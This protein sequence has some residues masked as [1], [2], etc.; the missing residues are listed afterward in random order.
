MSPCSFH[1]CV[2]QTK[3]SAS[4][5]SHGDMRT[6]NSPQTT[7]PF[8]APQPNNHHSPSEMP[9]STGKPTKSEPWKENSEMPAKCSGFSSHSRIHSSPASASPAPISP[10]ASSAATTTTTSTSAARNSVSSSPTSPVKASPQDS[11][12]RCAAVHSAPSLPAKC[13][14]PR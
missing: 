1:R 11:S 8:F 6:G 7:S 14:P 9:A 5:L 3:T 13:R 12:W 10:P 4:L 2:M